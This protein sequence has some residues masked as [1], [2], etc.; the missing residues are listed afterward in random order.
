MNKLIRII[1]VSLFLVLAHDGYAHSSHPELEISAIRFDGVEMSDDDRSYAFYTVF[2]DSPLKIGEKLYCFITPVDIEN[3]PFP[4]GNDSFLTSGGLFEVLRQGCSSLTIEIPV[5][6][7]KRTYGTDEYNIKVSVF[8]EPDEE[9][10][11]EES[12][13]FSYY[14]LNQEIKASAMQASYDLLDSF[15]G[16]D[17]SEESGFFKQKKEKSCPRCYG[18]GVCP[19]CRGAGGSYCH[20]CVD[21]G[22]CSKCEGSGHIYEN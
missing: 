16:G 17:D 18:S 12:Y 8:S 22:K 13:A 2:F 20:A 15:F 5:S 3:N 10:L 19:I 9:L 14:D 7:I 6:Y 11:L 1:T 21:T 4:D